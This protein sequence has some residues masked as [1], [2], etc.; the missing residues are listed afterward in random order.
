MS[1]Y[2]KEVEILKDDEQY[3]GEY[4]KQ[5]LSSSDMKVLNE[6]PD[7][8]H[9]EQG[10]TLPLLKGTYF[11]KMI[12]EPDK[13]VEFVIFEGASRNSKAYKEFELDNGL[14]LLQK[15]VYELEALFSA[16]MGKD[17]IRQLI[18]DPDNQY[19]VP[20]VSLIGGKLF[21]GKADILNH[22]AKLC[23]DLKTC[24]DINRF[25]YSAREYYYDSQAYIYRKHFGYNVIF[26]VCCKKTKVVKIFTCSEE[27]LQ[28]GEDRVISGLK[29][30]ETFYSEDSIEDVEQYVATIEL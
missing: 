26:I 22:T 21:K 27:F 13:L 11:H 7:K 24:A 4:G 3:Y 6:Q 18:D 28:S 2:S 16:I 14:C 10:D 5:F 20:A 12:L 25:K 23:I 17:I 15:E 30:H 1:D 29:N 19:E 8:F 9:V